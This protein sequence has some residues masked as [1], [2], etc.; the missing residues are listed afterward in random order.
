MMLRSGNAGRR[1][2][3]VRARVEKKGIGHSRT[4]FRTGL[5]SDFPWIGIGHLLSLRVG[6]TK[7]STPGCQRRLKL[8]SANPSGTNAQF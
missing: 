3:R 7:M 8:F 4:I 2:G 6:R 5:S 1:G